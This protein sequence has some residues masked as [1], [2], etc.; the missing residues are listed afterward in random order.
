MKKALLACFLFISTLLYAEPIQGGTLVF[1]RNADSSLLDPGQ[2]TD[3]ES[4]YVTRQLYDGLMKFKP[5]STEVEPGLAKSYEVS[6]D[7]LTYTFHLREGVYFAPTSYF[8]ERVEMTA[9]DVV[10]SLKRQFDKSSPY[11]NSNITYDY[12]VSMGMDNIVKDVEKVD[13]YTVKITLKKHEAPFLA[14]I[15]MDFAGIVCK[16]YAD[17]LLEE[18]KL[19][20]LARLPVGTGP[21]YFV[22]WKKDDTIILNANKD[23]WGQKPYLDRVVIKV[24]PNASVRAAELKIGSIHVMDRPNFSELD[25]LSKNANIKILQDPGVNTYYV[26]MNQNKK[27]FQNPL[28]RQAFNHAINKEAIVK[29]V[30]EGYARVAYSPLPPTIWGYTDDIVKYEYNPTLAKELLVKAGYPDGF[31]VNLLSRPTP[32]GKKL[33]EAVQA[34][35]AKIGINVN[36]QNYDFTTYIKIIKNLEHEMAVNSWISDNGDPDNFLYTILSKNSINK[37]AM[38]FSVWSNDEFDAIVTKAKESLNHEERIELYKK[39]QQ[40]FAKDIPWVTIANQSNVVPVLKKVQGFD[41]G[42]IWGRRFNI[43]W[44]EK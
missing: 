26:S 38:N 7:G 43:V 23:Y 37:P 21:F 15:A 4:L 16:K 35:L 33:A 28:V 13:K 11:H 6:E 14:N 9:D 36:I 39:A 2:I 25:E 27:E 34:D 29:A 10:F 22:S 12:W 8:K 5:G 30:Y 41:I 18:N 1:A 24:I 31:S 40:I 32:E 20:D 44:I 3:A 19:D 42:N 17:K